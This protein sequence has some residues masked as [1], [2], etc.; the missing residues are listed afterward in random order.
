[1]DMLLLSF[2]CAWVIRWLVESKSDDHQAAQRVKPGRATTGGW[3]AWQLRHGWGATTRDARDGYGYARPAHAEWRDRRTAGRRWGWWQALREA[4]A[5]GWASAGEEAARRRGPVPPPPE[6]EPTERRRQGE[7]NNPSDPD[8]SRPADPHPADPRPSRPDDPRPADPHSSDRPTDWPTDDAPRIT[9]TRITNPKEPNMSGTNLPAINGEGGGYQGAL[10]LSAAVQNGLTALAGSL[11]L[12][13]AE[14][15]AGG[16][17]GDPK[18]MQTLAA[19]QES[20]G[21]MVRMFAAHKA[22]LLTHAQ[23]A[24]YA[25]EKGAAAAN[26]QWLKAGA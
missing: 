11:E 1:M 24:E 6:P 9:V 10:R 25:V 8:P 13:E 23:G 14:L 12:Y 20:L 5:N 15:I 2:A 19:A 18:V 21:T 26:T 17:A 7:P 22:A 3:A 4:W 16:I